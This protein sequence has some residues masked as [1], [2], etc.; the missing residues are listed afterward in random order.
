MKNRASDSEKQTSRALGNVLLTLHNAVSLDGC[1]WLDFASFKQVK[2]NKC[3]V[4]PFLSN[5]S[6]FAF[7][8]NLV[9]I[10][11]FLASIDMDG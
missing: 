11:S 10:H 6:N 1:C 9:K 2:Q 4:D 5:F 8:S 7:L 3:E